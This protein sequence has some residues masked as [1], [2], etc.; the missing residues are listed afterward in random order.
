MSA[1]NPRDTDFCLLIVGNA[2]YRR[3][4]ELSRK[5]AGKQLERGSL[6]ELDCACEQPSRIG[7]TSLHSDEFPVPAP[8]GR[9]P[10]N[11]SIQEGGGNAWPAI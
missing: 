4:V 8:P 3:A 10:G 7:T 9:N 1:T 5:V 2:V 6:A 11:T